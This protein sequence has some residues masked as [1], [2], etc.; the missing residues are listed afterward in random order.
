MTSKL[1]EGFGGVG[2][3]NGPPPLTLA[4]ASNTAYCATA[5]TRDL[6]VK[7]ALKC[8]DFRQ[9]AGP[10]NRLCSFLSTAGLYSVRVLYSG[11]R[12]GQRQQAASHDDHGEAAGGAE[13]SL[14]RESQAGEARPR[15]AQCRDRA[16]HA[17]RTGTIRYDTIRYE[18]LF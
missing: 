11:V 7:V 6:T 16:R 12:S 18:M 17:R 15:T 14:Q 1:V 8:V 9:K 13:A 4:L 2:C 3:E 10:K 5:H